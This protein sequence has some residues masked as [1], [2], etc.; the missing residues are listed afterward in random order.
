[1]IVFYWLKVYDSAL[2]KVYDL[3]AV[4]S[5]LFSTYIF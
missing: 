5:K 4:V 1:M 3:Q 2:L